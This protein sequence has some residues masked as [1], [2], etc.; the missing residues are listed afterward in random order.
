MPLASTTGH[1]G[2]TAMNLQFYS[3]ES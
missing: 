3:N 2:K 1:L